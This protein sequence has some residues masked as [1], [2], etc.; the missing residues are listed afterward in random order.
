MGKDKTKGAFGSLHKQVETQDRLD[1][2]Y[3]RALGK[4]SI[5]FSLLH[6]LLEQFGWEIWSMNAHLAPILTRDFPTKQLVK[7]LRDSSEFVIPKEEELKE[8][9]SILTRAEKAAE[10]RNEFLHSIWIIKEGKP[11]LCISRKRG[12]LVGPDAPSAEN[13]DDLSR[14]IMNIV[15]DLM[16]FKGEDPLVSF[17]RRV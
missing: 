1:A 7:K 17:G 9:L 5:R 14:S 12:R 11:T 8:F 10:K 13:I 16:R 6:S 3:E 4:L 2:P 15:A